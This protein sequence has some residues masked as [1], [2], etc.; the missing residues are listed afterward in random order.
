MGR[1]KIELP[2]VWSYET[3]MDVR[4]TDLNYGNHLANQNF[5]AIAQ[6][7]RLRFFQ[8]KG[9]AELDFAGVS[10]IQA[11]AAITFKAEGFYGDRLLIKVA[12]EP[13]GK[14]AFNVFYEVV[15]KESKQVLAEM[16][17]AVVC[18]D[19]DAK[20]PVA[21]PDEVFDSGLFIS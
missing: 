3:E 19:Y 13:T 18:Y 16:R 10:L 12:A 21:I 2:K 4:I 1:M 6:E 17:T 7:A 20:K 5:L 14:F 9:Y 15:N 8:S 11:D